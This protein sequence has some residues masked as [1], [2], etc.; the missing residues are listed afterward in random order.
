MS[1]AD[2]ET[3]VWRAGYYWP[4][5]YFAGG[6]ILADILRGEKVLSS[7]IRLHT[8]IAIEI[9]LNEHLLKCHALFQKRLSR[10]RAII[11]PPAKR[12]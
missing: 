10:E 9:S 4:S 8:V 1:C 11:G 6:L 5:S 12:H 2:P 7:A 3:F